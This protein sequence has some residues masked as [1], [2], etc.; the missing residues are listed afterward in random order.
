MRDSFN[1]LVETISIIAGT[2][3]QYSKIC[4]SGFDMKDLVSKHEPK[5]A[6]GETNDE[7]Q[8]PKIYTIRSSIQLTGLELEDRN[9]DTAIYITNLCTPQIDNHITK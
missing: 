2:I 3:H 1:Q 4:S 5:Y 6:A 7:W 8:T 9:C